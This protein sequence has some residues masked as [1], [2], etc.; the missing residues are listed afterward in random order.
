LCIN[1]CVITTK[2]RGNVYSIFYVVVTLFYTEAEAMSIFYIV[3][4]GG[5]NVKIYYIV[6]Y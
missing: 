2:K 3:A 4:E 1:L 5:P 6:I